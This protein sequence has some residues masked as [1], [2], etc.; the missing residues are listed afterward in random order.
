MFLTP[1]DLTE[2][3][4]SETPPVRFL[5][6]DQ[7]F[8]AALAKLSMS[9]QTA[10]PA[11]I[12]GQTGTGKTSLL[13]LFQGALTKSR[14]RAVYLHLTHISPAALPR[15]IAAGLGETP[16]LGK[17]RVFVQILERVR[18]TDATT[19]LIIDEAHLLPSQA[20]TDL[21]LLI[22]SGIDHTL[23]LQV[24]LCGQEPLAQTLKRS[25]HADLVG[26][27][28][29]RV[30]LKAMTRQQTADYIDHRIH[31]AGG[32]ENLFDP[33]AKSLIHD[34]AGGIPRQINNI[35]TSCLINA[36][37]THKPQVDEDLVNETM[38]EFNLP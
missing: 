5:Q 27:I 29:A 26:R 2:H 16:K 3:P 15:M 11:L 14:C 12:I 36:A 18:K 33:E 10:N 24:I 35:A 19:V 4:F 21:R 7:R 20:L 31:A 13:R 22:S 30:W 9:L 6:K 23:G 34:Y 37:T 8:E 17:D 38:A 1:F 28:G 32:A 25:V